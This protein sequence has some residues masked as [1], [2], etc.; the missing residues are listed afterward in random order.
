MTT[1]PTAIPPTL[2]VHL[3][4]DDLRAALEHDVRAGLT[5]APK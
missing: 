3:T 2:D 5:A 4:A 1:E